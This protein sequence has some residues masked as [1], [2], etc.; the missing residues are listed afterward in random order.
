MLNSMKTIFFSVYLA[1]LL[2]S[3]IQ[4]FRSILLWIAVDV[5]IAT[6]ENYVEGEFCSQFAREFAVINPS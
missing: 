5:N 4:R 1:L 2:I 3:L 6:S